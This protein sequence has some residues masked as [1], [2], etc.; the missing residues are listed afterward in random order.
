[1]KLEATCL[2]F[3]RRPQFRFLYPRG[4]RWDQVQ[5][6]ST[7]PRRYGFTPQ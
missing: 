7:T 2:Q 1:M 5:P 4:A 6:A 3:Q